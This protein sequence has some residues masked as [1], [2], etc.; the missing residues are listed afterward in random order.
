MAQQR[1]FLKPEE[2]IAALNDIPEDVSEA[3]PIDFQQ[4][5]IMEN[6]L[7]T[8]S[9][10]SEDE[11]G[12]EDYVQPVNIRDYARPG[13]CELVLYWNSFQNSLRALRAGYS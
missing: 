6:E 13:L 12:D 10:S 11:Q 2:I 4:E 3:D 8:D 5:Q 7:D 1:R 9:S